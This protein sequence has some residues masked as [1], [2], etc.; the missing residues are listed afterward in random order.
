MLR[1]REKNAGPQ[2]PE[3]YVTNLITGNLCP[4]M[5]LGSNLPNLYQVVLES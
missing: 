3:L 5:R 1:L 4:N 2:E